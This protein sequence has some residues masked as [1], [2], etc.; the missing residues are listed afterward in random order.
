LKYLPPLLLEHIIKNTVNHTHTQLGHKFDAEA[1]VALV[2]AFW[3]F[4]EHGFKR[5]F[6]NN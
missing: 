3:V 4:G 5:D 6:G 2:D 1:V